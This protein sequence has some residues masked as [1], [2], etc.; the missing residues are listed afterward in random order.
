MGNNITVFSLSC[1]SAAAAAA[2]VFCFFNA[3]ATVAIAYPIVFPVP[4]RALM[5]VDC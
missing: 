2:A 1:P 5:S 3:F 4:V